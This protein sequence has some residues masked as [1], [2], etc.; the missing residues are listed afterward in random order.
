MGEH[1]VQQGDDAITPLSDNVMETENFADL[2]LPEAEQGFCDVPGR[3]RTGAGQ[4]VLTPDL[5]LEA[6][7]QLAEIMQKREERQPGHG[8]VGKVVH[9][10]R[11]NEARPQDRIAEQCFEA[12]R[13]VRAM[14]LETM[15]AA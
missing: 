11:A 8:R 3:P 14:M 4:L 15:K 6:G 2:R 13:N 7:V 10:C 9:T 5:E 12:R 1:R